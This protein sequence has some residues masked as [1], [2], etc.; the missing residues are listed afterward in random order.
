V[1][2]LNIWSL[3]SWW[4]GSI[5]I[6]WTVQSTW[7]TLS[8][9][10]TIT[11]N[12]L[13][14]N[15]WNNTSSTTTT[16]VTPTA[17]LSITK[18]VNSTWVYFWSSVVYTLSYANAWPATATWIVISDTLPSGLTG[19]TTSTWSVSWNVFTLNIWSLLSWWVW[20]VIITW[21]VQSTWGT[22]SNFATITWNQLDLNTGNNTSSTVTTTIIPTANLS[23]TKSVNSTWVYF[24]SSVVYTLSYANAGPATATWI[25]IS[26][27]LPTWL[28]WFVASTWSISWN[29]FTLNIW[30]LLSWSAGTI[31]ITWT[32]QST[33]GTLSNFATITW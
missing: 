33:W 21:T 8:N 28:T 12:Q 6:T 17:D 14:T 22:L 29:V 1:F 18:S 25:V 13:D 2:T 7:G 15:T 30:S 23:I 4:A 10:A 9:F 31:T 24:W 20:S 19:F 32:V 26:D 16:T 3:L 27:T 11:W 5:V